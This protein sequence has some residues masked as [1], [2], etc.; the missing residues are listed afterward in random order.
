MILINLEHYDYRAC[1]R[2]YSVINPDHIVRVDYVNLPDKDNFEDFCR[3]TMVDGGSYNIPGDVENFYKMLSDSS[4]PIVGYRMSLKVC[5]PEKDLLA[6]SSEVSE[7]MKKM[8]ITVVNGESEPSSGSITLFTG[9][10]AHEESAVRAYKDTFVPLAPK[11]KDCNFYQNYNKLQSE[12]ANSVAMPAVV[13]SESITTG[14]ALLAT[15]D[16]KKSV[17]IT[18]L[19]AHDETGS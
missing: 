18:N 1:E 2:K 3:I 13:S 9:D 17:L 8:G 10:A 5:P 11:D 19:G 14:V 7:M 6:N 15:Q 16:P 4:V 12:I